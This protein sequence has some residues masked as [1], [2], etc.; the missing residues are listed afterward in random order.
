[1]NP[2]TNCET[3]RSLETIGGQPFGA[4]VGSEV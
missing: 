4:T 1:M 2:Y 3:P